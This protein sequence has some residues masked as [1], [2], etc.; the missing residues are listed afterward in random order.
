MAKANPFENE[1]VRTTFLTLIRK[2]MN[3]FDALEDMGLS[4]SQLQYAKRK[5]PDFDEAIILACE[6]SAAEVLDTM[7]SLAL[8]GDTAAASIYLKYT[9][10]TAD[11]KREE[12]PKVVRHEHE[13][14]PI[15]P[16]TV[17]DLAAFQEALERRRELGPSTPHYDYDLEP[18]EEE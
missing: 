6:S 3:Q 18:E 15:S 4:P 8:Q 16:E 1:V 10:P 13:L 5:W 11:K 9:T 12:K 7:K 17:K 2:G 14:V